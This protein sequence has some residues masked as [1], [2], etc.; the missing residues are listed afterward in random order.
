MSAAM[1]ISVVGLGPYPA[2]DRQVTAGKPGTFWDGT[3][4]AEVCL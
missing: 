4:A 3:I 2:V 1:D